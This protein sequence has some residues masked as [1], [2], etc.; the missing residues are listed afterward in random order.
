MKSAFD[1]LT[2]VDIFL[3]PFYFIFLFAIFRV[4]KIYKIKDPVEQKYFIPAFLSKIV[5]AVVLVLIYQ[6]YYKGGDTTAFFFDSQIATTLFFDS[7]FGYLQFLLSSPGE[8]IPEISFYTFQIYFYWDPNSL[9]IVKIA[10][11]LNILTFSSFVCT[12]MLFGVLGF[13][14]GWYFFKT[15]RLLNKHLNKQFAFATLF[16]PSII[17]WGSGLIK[18]TLTM[19]AIGFIMYTSYKLFVSKDV[20]LK[21]VIAMSIAMYL[22]IVIKVYILICLLPALCIWFFI[23]YINHIKSRS[24][25]GFL[26]PLMLSIAILIGLIGSSIIVETDTKYNFKNI[27]ETA[28]VTANYI[29]S[30]SKMENGSYYN[31]GQLE[32]TPGGIISIFPSAIVVSLFRP[33]LWEIKNLLMTLSSLESLFVMILVISTLY[34]VGI[35][36]FISIVNGNAFI[37]SAIIFSLTFAFAVGVSTSNFGT[38]ARYKTPLIPFFVSSLYMIRNLAKTSATKPS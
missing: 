19:S 26:K 7:P 20:R 21:Y 9:I 25:R 27:S 13:C 5:G 28:K 36:K 16:M 4:I 22:V 11:F 10:S 35:F 31:I 23:N 2:W 18:D 12:S 33:F 8:Q 14:G 37:L 29:G 32:M 3:P 24:T 34:K 38:L 6:F 17:I 15:L 30:V 1:V